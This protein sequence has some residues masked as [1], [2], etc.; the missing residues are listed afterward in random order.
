M[1]DASADSS[2]MP[3]QV[4]PT[5]ATDSD[6]DE[7][8]RRDLTDYPVPYVEP[9]PTADSPVHV[10]DVLDAAPS[11]SSDEHIDIAAMPRDRLIRSSRHTPRI[12][13][14]AGWS[15]PAQWSSGKQIEA[16]WHMYATEAIATVPF[17]NVDG[18]PTVVPA[19]RSYRFQRD[20][21]RPKMDHYIRQMLIDGPGFICGD[22]VL[23][24]R[25]ANRPEPVMAL[26]QIGRV[27]AFYEA[28]IHDPSNINL[29]SEV[30]RGIMVRCLPHG[31]PQQVC[32]V[33][34]NFI[35]AR[36]AHAPMPNETDVLTHADAQVADVMIGV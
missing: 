10:M 6:D 4:T 27:Q 8:F 12:Q 21:P 3:E 30:A 22:P 13:L 35:D 31:T 7:A 16:L 20:V 17:F 29:A 26:T 9:F 14:P 2:G 15:D 28:L 34:S 5:P 1:C 23:C 18:Y 36:A 25:V 33:L 24:L 11:L 19:P 32:A